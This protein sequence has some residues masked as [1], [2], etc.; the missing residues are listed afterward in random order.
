MRVKLPL[1]SFSRVPKKICCTDQI[2]WLTNI[3]IVPF[4]H[5]LLGCSNNKLLRKKE[6]RSFN[7]ELLKV[8]SAKSNHDNNS[9]GKDSTSN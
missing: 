5:K 3:C 9:V 6:F 2:N 1:N 4:K 7:L 8:K